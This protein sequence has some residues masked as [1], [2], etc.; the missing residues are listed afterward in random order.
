[1]AHA[2]ALEGQLHPA[3]SADVVRGMRER[4][5][6]PLPDPPDSDDDEPMPQAESPKPDS[7]DEP[8]VRPPSPFPDKEDTEWDPE[9]EPLVRPAVRQPVPRYNPDNTTR[10]ELEI[11]L[12][13]MTGEPRA[14]FDKRFFP[15]RRALLAEINRRNIMPMI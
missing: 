8:L 2:R 14:N 10:W 13:D 11:F 1:M 4:R 9:L 15:N 5:E 7:D 6:L 3:D 12:A